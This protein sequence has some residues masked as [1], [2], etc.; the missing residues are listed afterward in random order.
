[1]WLLRNAPANNSWENV[2]SSA[3]GTKLVAVAVNGGSGIYTSTNS[4]AS[5]TKQPNAPTTA[6]LRVA[7]SADG[8]RLVTTAWNASQ[9]YN[10][11]DSGVTWTT[12]LL[13][14]FWYAVASSADGCRLVANG[15]DRVF[16]S[17]TIPAPV[18]GLTMKNEKACVSWV[19]PSLDFKLQ[20][21]LDPGS[22]SWADITNEPA[23]N[24]T[25]LQDE[26]VL[27]STGSG[28]YRLRTP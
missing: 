21:S 25:N 12:N 6:M 5:W 15:G 14:K 18:L 11:T 20:T 16:V 9:I 2:A 10:S 4:G 28:F 8:G 19:V 22:A 24:L 7:S 26:V 17:Q 23:L 13:T 1:T 27:P 3:D